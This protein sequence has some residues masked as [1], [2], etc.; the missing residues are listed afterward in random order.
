VP[1]PVVA[2]EMRPPVLDSWRAM[3]ELR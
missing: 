3:P 1:T 2:I